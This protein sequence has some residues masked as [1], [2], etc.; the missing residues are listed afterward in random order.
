VLSGGRSSRL[1]RALVEEGKVAS[2]VY[3]VNGSPGARFENLFC[4]F[5]EP[6]QGV[7]VMTAVEAA[8]KELAALF[9]NPPRPEELERVKKAILADSV[10]GLVSDVG[11]ARKLS[12]FETVAGDWRYIE[13]HPEVLAS[14]TP[15]EAARTAK[16]YF[17]PSNETLAFIPDGGERGEGEGR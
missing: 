17:T 5:I 4:V 7:P 2:E 3:T 9:S 6:A 15:E 8:R 11:L 13:R 16:A 1:W 14:I 12:Y 10:R